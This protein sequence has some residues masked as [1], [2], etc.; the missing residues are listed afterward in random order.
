M[1]LL[2]SL[3]PDWLPLFSAQQELPYF[4]ELEEF[5][6]KAYASNQVFPPFNLLFNAFNHCLPRDVKVVILGQDPYH[7]DHQ[8]HGLAFSVPESVA[9]P[10]SLRNIF[11]ELEQ[12][13]H[14]IIPTSGNLEHWANQGVLLLNAVLSVQKDMPASHAQ[15]GWEELS[16]SVIRYLNLEYNHLVF[17][18]WGNYA[19]SKKKFIDASRHLILEAAHPSPLSAH[20]G[21]FGCRH[22]SKTN[23]YLSQ[24]QKNPISW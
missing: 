20:R 13:L 24:H 14:I 17:M 7:G 23:A 1:R 3:H 19:R 4:I 10:P 22:F 5:V 16:D 15:K 2:D 6:L 11:K 18:L 21:F 8:A 9:F 12:D